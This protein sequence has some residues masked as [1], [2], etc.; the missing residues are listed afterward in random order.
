M[1][2]KAYEKDI[3][4]FRFPYK[5]VHPHEADYMLDEDTSRN[6]QDNERFKFTLL[7]LGE[8]KVNIFVYF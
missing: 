7:N 4:Y 3:R 1:F 6:D 5:S 2:L 8:K